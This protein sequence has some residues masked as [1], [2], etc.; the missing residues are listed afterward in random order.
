[1]ANREQD[2]ANL[3]TIPGI[4]RLGAEIILAETGGKMAQFASAHHL[5]SWIGVCPGQN[6]SAGVSKSG[7]TRP[8][9]QQPQTPAWDRRHGRAQE[10]GL[11]PR[12]LLPPPGRPTRRQTGSRRGDAQT[13]HRHLARP[14]RQNRLPRARRLPLHPARSRTRHAP[15]AQRSQQPRPDRPLRTHHSLTGS[16]TR[17]FCVSPSFG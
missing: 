4:G 3:A 15:H 5:A 12:R 17:H 6:E 14:S 8:G 13:C 9:Q 16:T 10:Q 2:L 11:L 7:R 1:M